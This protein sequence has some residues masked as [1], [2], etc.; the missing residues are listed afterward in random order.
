MIRAELKTTTFI[1]LIFHFFVLFDFINS[2]R[3]LDALLL[4]L[5]AFS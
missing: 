5:T 1:L 4:D 2:G 3:M